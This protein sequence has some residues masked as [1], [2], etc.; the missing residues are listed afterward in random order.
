MNLKKYQKYLI[1]SKPKE[2]L[3]LDD[4]IE[5]LEHLQQILQYKNRKYCKKFIR[6]MI[7]R[8]ENAR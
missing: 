8:I 2:K 3:D 7:K 4:L 6:D 1:M 5:D